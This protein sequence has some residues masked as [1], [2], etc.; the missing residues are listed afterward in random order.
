MFEN[1]P[2][3]QSNLTNEPPVSIDNRP[4]TDNIHISGLPI[5][6]NSDISLHNCP[7][8]YGFKV[9]DHLNLKLVDDTKELFLAVVMREDAYNTANGETKPRVLFKRVG[10][11]FRSSSIDDFLVSLDQDLQQKNIWSGDYCFYDNG[12]LKLV[13]MDLYNAGLDDV[14]LLADL[15]TGNYP[16][17]VNSIKRAFNLLGSLRGFTVEFT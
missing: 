15:I 11:N 1:Q 5:I 7:S 6:R 2:L 14:R 12:V 10:S 13:Q 17:K 3:T 9:M 8:R 16:L 4:N